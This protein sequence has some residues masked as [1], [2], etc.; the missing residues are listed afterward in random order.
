MENLDHEG[1]S[2]PDQKAFSLLLTIYYKA[3]QVGLSYPESVFIPCCFV[4]FSPLVC[5]KVV[6]NSLS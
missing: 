2:L 6:A 4:V 1:F 5:E 3:C